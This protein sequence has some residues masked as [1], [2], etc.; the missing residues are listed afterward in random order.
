MASET[1]QKALDYEAA[2][3]TDILPE[4]RPLLHLTPRIGWMN[5]PNGFSFYDDTYHLFYQYHPYG[6]DWGPMHWGHARSKD[7][8]HWEFLPAALAPDQEYDRFGCFSGS[9][10]ALPDGRQLLMYTGVRQKPR[11]D[12]RMQDV[13]TQCLAIGDG[14]YYEKLD[15]NPVLDQK[16]L[17]EGASPADFRDPKIWQANDGSFRC[18]TGNRPADGSGQLLLF[19][20]TDGLD[21]HFS[22]VFFENKCRYGKMLECPDF[23]ELDG[24]AVLLVSPQDTLPDGKE[25]P[26]GHAAIALLGRYDA[27][28]DAFTEETMQGLDFGLDFYAPQSVQTP[29]GRRVLIGWLQN[30]D[31]CG[32]R[33]EDREN[34]WFGQMSIPR[35]ISLQDGR[36][37]QWPIRELESC[38]SRHI[39]FQGKRIL[40]ETSFEGVSG[41]VADLSLVLHLKPDC[42]RIT[43][44]CAKGH[45]CYT[46]LVLEY[47]GAGTGRLTLD[48]TNSGT[49]RAL[50][51]TSSCDVSFDPDAGLSL[52]LILD[53]FSMEAFIEGGRRVLSA[54]IYTEPS[55]EGIT[56]AADGEAILDLDFYQLG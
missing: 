56:F 37:C 8:L 36:L 47:T 54:A 27:E 7:L 34:K 16:D 23:F 45:G 9:A 46:S 6:T 32:H 48:R 13:Q 39:S 49:R 4:D 24:K 15:T 21:W 55:A 5:D 17:P 44:Q 31:S 10:A 42:K 29:D 14:I 19:H 18:L 2:H 22:K 28:T 41:R 51:H 52:R 53:R 12:G 25:L 40:E 11:E 30:W 50:R 33:R 43:I 35:E 38:R 20:S 26:G 3:E 1:L